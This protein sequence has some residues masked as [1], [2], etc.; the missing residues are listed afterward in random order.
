M[1]TKYLLA[2]VFLIIA[3]QAQQVSVGDSEEFRLPAFTSVFKVPNLGASE[4]VTVFLQW[5]EGALPSGQTLQL[6]LNPVS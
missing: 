3:A 6:F 1:S 4:S 2:F 5:T